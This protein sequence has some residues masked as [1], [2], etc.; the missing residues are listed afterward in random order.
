MNEGMNEGRKKGTKEPTHEGSLFGE[1]PGRLPFLLSLCEVM[2]PARSSQDCLLT[3]PISRKPQK[4]S[5]SPD[6]PPGQHCASRRGF[7]PPAAAPREAEVSWAGSGPC[8]VFQTGDFRGAERRAFLDRVPTG[9]Q[10]P[11]PARI[12]GVHSSEGIRQEVST[13]SRGGACEDEA[14][15]RA[16]ASLFSKGMKETSPRRQPAHS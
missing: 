16:G 11:G 4:P 7:G 5:A 14:A 9:S 6:T 12:L 10:P 15:E 13:R 1:N 3:K 8:P 2:S